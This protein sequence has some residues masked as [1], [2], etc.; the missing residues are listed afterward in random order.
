[1]LSRYVW[2]WSKIAQISIFVTDDTKTDV[3]NLYKDESF[4]KLQYESGI[5]IAEDSLFGRFCIA[6]VKSKLKSKDGYKEILTELKSLEKDFVDPS[7]FEAFMKKGL[8]SKN[9]MINILRCNVVTNALL[10]HHLFSR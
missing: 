5:H 10:L 2:K 3:S 4:R 1:M 9:W 7:K 8:E 6:L